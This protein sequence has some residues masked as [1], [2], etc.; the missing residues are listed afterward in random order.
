MKI[1]I[2]SRDVRH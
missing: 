1:V 2:T